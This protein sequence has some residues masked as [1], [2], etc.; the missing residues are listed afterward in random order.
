MPRLTNVSENSASWQ[1][2]TD[3]PGSNTSGVVGNMCVFS[4][5]CWFVLCQYASAHHLYCLS[6]DKYC[7]SGFC[8][9]LLKKLAEEIG[10]DF[11]LYQVQDQKWGSKNEYGE[12]NG[13]IKDLVS[14]KYF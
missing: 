9:D 2:G 7:C 5:P 1:N 13:L 10:F 3:M 12:W 14:G 8:I 4:S 6:E 11:K